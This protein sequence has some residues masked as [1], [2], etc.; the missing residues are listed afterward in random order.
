MRSPPAGAQPTS[1]LGTGSQCRRPGR[2]PGAWRETN[3]RTYLTGSTTWEPA[4][5]WPSLKRPAVKAWPG[6]PVMRTR[7]AGPRRF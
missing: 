7:T 1:S 2:D 4:S 5:G 6:V 3:I